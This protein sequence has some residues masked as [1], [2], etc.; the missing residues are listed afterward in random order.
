MASVNKTAIQNFHIAYRSGDRI[1]FSQNAPEKLF[2]KPPQD[3]AEV[4]FIPNLFEEKDVPTAFMGKL[5]QLLRLSLSKIHPNATSALLQRQ[6][7]YPP[8]A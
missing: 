1:V 4:L 3:V 5:T 6:Q 8:G 2:C 7:Q